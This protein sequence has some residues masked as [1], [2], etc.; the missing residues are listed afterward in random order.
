MKIAKTE[1]TDNRLL[2]LVQKENSNFYFSDNHIGIIILKIGIPINP[3]IINVAFLDA[4]DKNFT[5]LFIYNTRDDKQL[6][7]QTML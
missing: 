5:E 4:A 6:P 1:I 2:N 3:K 7:S